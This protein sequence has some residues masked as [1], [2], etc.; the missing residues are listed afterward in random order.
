MMLFLLYNFIATLDT[1]F[2]GTDLGKRKRAFLGL[3]GLSSND[4]L[5]V[6]GKYPEIAEAFGFN[7]IFR[8]VMQQDRQKLEAIPM[9]D[10]FTEGILEIDIYERNIL[11]ASIT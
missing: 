5:Q 8:A 1:S 9:G 4:F 11:H 2:C 6:W 10:Q 3:N 7:D